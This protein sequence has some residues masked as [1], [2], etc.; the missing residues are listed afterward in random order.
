[1]KA[2]CEESQERLKKRIQLKV[3]IN[4]MIYYRC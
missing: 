3:T 2:H 4:A 1:V